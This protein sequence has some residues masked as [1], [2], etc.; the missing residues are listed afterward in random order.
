MKALAPAIL[1]VVLFEGGCSSSSS[2]S[3]CS[4]STSTLTAT[5]VNDENQGANICNATVKASGPT[6]ITLGP[7]GGPGSC[8]YLGS[9]PA[10]SYKVTATAAGYEPYTTQITIQPGCSVPISMDMTPAPP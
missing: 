5:V 10:G 6:D 4:G 8:D 7:A 3:Q 2:T 9:V 1:A